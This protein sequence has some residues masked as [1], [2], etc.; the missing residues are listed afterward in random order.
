[1]HID[2]TADEERTPGEGSEGQRDRRFTTGD[3][4][5]RRFLKMTGATAGAGAILGGSGT[6]AASEP[7]DPYSDRFI[8]A[9]SNHYQED[10]R[11][12]DDINWI[13]I[14]VAVGTYEGTVNYFQQETQTRPDGT[15][16]SVSA[17][18]VISNYEHTGGDPGDITQMVQHKDIAQHATATNPPSIG[19]EH[20]WHQDHGRYVTEECYERSG[21][22]ISW[23]CDEYDIPK[24]YYED[25]TCVFSEPGGIIGHTHA[26]TASDCS[27]YPSRSCPYPDGGIDPD[28]LMSYVNGDDGG[29]HTFEVDDGVVPTTDLN[30]REGPGLNHDVVVA[31]DEGTVCRV[32]DGPEYS[33]DYTWWRLYA[34]DYDA[35]VWSTEHHLEEVEFYYDEEVHTTTDLNGRQG[36]GLNYDV[37]NTYPE[38]TVGEIMNGPNENDDITWWGVH[39]PDYNDWV[40]CSGT[41]L[42]RH[43]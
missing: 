30:G 23:L 41:Y 42:T 29:D 10:W 9:H 8:S 20:E 40:W 12:A 13:V 24:V 34:D 15:E 33:D 4:D 1:M 7:D 22:L 38:G 25:P 31:M 17:H 32:L 18:Y 21:Q 11:G 14:H 2:R 26:P 37:V 39:F 36:P 27:S 5:R 28:T 3:V 6:A 16:V 19:I 35:Y 43:E